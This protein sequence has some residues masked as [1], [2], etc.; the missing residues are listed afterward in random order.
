M[1]R[2]AGVLYGNI[3]TEGEGSMAEK[4]VLI[5]AGTTEGRMLVKDLAGHGV[6]VH[7]CAATEYGAS[8]LPEGGSVTVNA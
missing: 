2:N 1:K 3:R 6:R 7:A 5:F 8:L 4:R